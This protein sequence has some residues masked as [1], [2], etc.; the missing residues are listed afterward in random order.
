VPEALALPEAGTT[1]RR[2][3]FRLETGETCMRWCGHPAAVTADL[4]HTAMR[5]AANW[6]IGP[7]APPWLLASSGLAP[8]HWF[9]TLV[10]KPWGQTTGG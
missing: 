1:L 3:V 5:L 6:T 7:E 9:S 8:N 4:V 10:E 2:S